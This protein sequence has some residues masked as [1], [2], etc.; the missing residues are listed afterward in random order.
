MKQIPGFPNYCATKDGRIWSKKRNKW[1]KPQHWGNYLRVALRHNKSTHQKSL[2]HVVLETFIE[3]R[4]K[5]ME[6]RH[7][8]D[9]PSNNKLSN[10]RWGTRKENIQD[11][12]KHKTHSGF[13]R[14]GEKN[15][16][17]KLK[18][19]DVK[20]IVYMYRTGLFIQKEIANFYRIDK[21]TVSNIIS[22]KTWKHIW[23][24]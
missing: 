6:C 11:Q 2:A 13:C 22:K 10:L 9:N 18:K 12:I 15:P 4:P 3:I 21:T 8:D 7:L 14:K 16:L 24:N 5:G 1:L 19:S 17:S 20:M 23:Y